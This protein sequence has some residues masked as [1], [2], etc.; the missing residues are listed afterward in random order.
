M[1]Q[2]TKSPAEIAAEETLA[3]VERER[4][5][6]IAAK[7]AARLESLRAAC[8]S[9]NQMLN[10]TH[11]EITY[12]V[13]WVSGEGQRHS[14][15]GKGIAVDIPP[16]ALVRSNLPGLKPRIEGAEKAWRTL[17]KLIDA[18]ERDPSKIPA[19]A[20]AYIRDLIATIP[21]G[22]KTMVMVQAPKPANDGL[23]KK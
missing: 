4:K 12:T 23:A 1:E 21:P 9:I 19:D 5:A 20:D 17:R 14:R 7:P 22:D 18:C 16:D 2:K 15:V 3:Q 10:N 6:K 8:R 13:A 11:D